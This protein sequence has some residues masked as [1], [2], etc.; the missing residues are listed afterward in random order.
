LGRA[1]ALA[2]SPD[3]AQ[4]NVISGQDDTFS[5]FNSDQTTGK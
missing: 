2:L 3:S 4:L 1:S 5:V